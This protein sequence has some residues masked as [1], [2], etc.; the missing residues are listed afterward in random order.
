[1]SPALASGNGLVEIARVQNYRSIFFLATV[2]GFAIATSAQTKPGWLSDYKKA[3]QEAKANNKLVLLDFTGSDWCGW[4][5]KLNKEVF[6]QPQFKDYASKALVLLEV[7]F[8]RQKAQSS[9]CSMATGGS[10][11]STTVI[12]P[13]GRPLLLRSWKNCA[14]AKRRL[15]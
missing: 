2:I 4:C 7:D 9:S 15:L 12:S 11:G 14:K 13:T 5:M 8:P 10:F 6:S 1:M 3:Q